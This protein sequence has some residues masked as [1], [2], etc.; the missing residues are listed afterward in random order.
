MHVAALENLLWLVQMMMYPLQAAQIAALKQDKI[1][2]K[3]PLEYANYADVFLFN[4]AME[5]LENTD[6]NKYTIDVRDGKQPPYAPTY[7]LGLIELE[8][9]K[10]YIETH[11]KTGF[12]WP[13]KSLANAFILFD[14]KPV[15]SF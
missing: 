6:I 12:I 4:L 14:E 7:S 13:S 15:G 1:P 3:V 2:I 10:I 9:L 5:L 11:F 8:I